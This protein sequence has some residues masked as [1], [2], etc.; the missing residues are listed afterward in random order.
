MTVSVIIPTYNNAK[1]ITDAIESVQR[2]TYK[3]TEIIVVDDGSTDNT[4]EMMANFSDIT[5]LQQYHQGPAVARNRGLREAHG[6]Y[7]QFLDSDDVLLPTK[8]EKCLSVFE[9][10]P[11]VGLVYTGYEVRTSDLSEPVAIQPPILQKPQGSDLMALI[12]STTTIFAPHCALIRQA[13]ID[14]VGGFNESLIGTEDWYLWISL[15]AQGTVFYHLDEILA[16]TRKHDT[17]LSSNVMNLAYARL[18]AYEALHQLD[19]PP[20]IVDVNYL[21]AGRH[22]ML[23]IRLWQAGMRAEARKHMLKAMKL[24]SQGRISRRVLLFLSYFVGVDVAVRLLSPFANFK[25]LLNS[26][27][28]PR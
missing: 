17:N 16:W 22:H 28:N 11:N 6:E 9:S 27:E 26:Y 8:L 20:D 15:A 5:Y 12:N 1:Y 10:H 23:A 18:N 19:I 14:T 3:D 21:I 2:Q 25:D 24:H 7:I 4:Q 13:C